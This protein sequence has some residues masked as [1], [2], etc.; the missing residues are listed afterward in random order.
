VVIIAILFFLVRL[1]TLKVVTVG[2]NIGGLNSEIP[3][4]EYS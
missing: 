3:L 4:A 1:N 2:P